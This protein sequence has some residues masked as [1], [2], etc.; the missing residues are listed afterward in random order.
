MHRPRKFPVPQALAVAIM[1]ATPT[2]AHAGRM[3]WLDDVLRQILADSRTGARSALHEPGSLKAGR[4][5]TSRKADRGLEELAQSSAELSRAKTLATEPAEALLDAR[6][7]R[8]VGETGAQ[9]AFRE[10]KPA[11]KRLVVEMGETVADLA[12]RHPAEAE[13]LIRR[14]GPD[15]VMAV[16]A[17]GDD[18]AGVL[19][20]EGPECLSVLRKT[21]RGGWDFFTTNVLPHKKKLAAAGVLAAFLADPERFVDYAGKATEYAAREFA[22]AGVSLAGATASGIEQALGDALASQGLKAPIFR[23]IAMA[24]AGLTAAIALLAL[25]GFPARRVLAPLAWVARRGR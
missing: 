8:L 22:R 2:L 9:T 18:I 17:F 11:E 24:A 4:L 25:I 19:A 23:K 10:M 5:F 12:R 3:S 13:G 14:L 7:G 15:G 16:R 1:L 21:G 20:Q 6:F